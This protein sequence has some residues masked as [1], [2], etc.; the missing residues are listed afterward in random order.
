[1]ATTNSQ[2]RGQSPS[3]TTVARRKRTGSRSNTTRRSTR[4]ATT[5]RAR[6]TRTAA[7]SHTSTSTTPIQQAGVLAER[8][9]LVPVGA[10]L[11]ARDNLVSTARDLASRYSTRTKV[12]QEIRRYERRGS[13]ARNRFERQ[14]RRTRTRFE[15]QLRQRRNL[16]QRTIKQNRRRVEREVRSVRRDLEKQ[17][18]VVTARVEK[19]VSDAQGLIASSR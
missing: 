1:M 7:R 19:L 5:R 9:V 18:G 12:E 16:V 4:S 3:S 11:L 6:S 8:A 2:S 14:V 13:T 10:T 17:S 15:R